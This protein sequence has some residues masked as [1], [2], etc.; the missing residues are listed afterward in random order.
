MSSLDKY[1]IATINSGDTQLIILEDGVTSSAPFNCKGCP[2]LAFRTPEL[3][4]PCDVTFKV[5]EQR[6]QTPTNPDLAD[7][8]QA[9]GSGLYTVATAAGGFYALNPQIFNAVGFINI[10]CSTAQLNA[11]KVVSLI[12]T[13]LWQGIHA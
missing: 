5:L 11:D 8:W 10:V 2:P 3:W 9:D 6:G 12:L 1:A 13:P 4:T 7:V